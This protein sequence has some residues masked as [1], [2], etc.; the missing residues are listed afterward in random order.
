VVM[1]LDYP[2]RL[3]LEHD[4][5]ATAKIGSVDRHR[6]VNLLWAGRA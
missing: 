3:T 4:G 1:E 5:H 6:A 2:A